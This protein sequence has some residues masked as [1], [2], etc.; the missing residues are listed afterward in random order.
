M[1]NVEIRIQEAMHCHVMEVSVCHHSV[2]K[3]PLVKLVATGTFVTLQHTMAY[4][5]MLL[6][7][8]KEFIPNCNGTF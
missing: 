8:Q 3:Q 4:H 7:M 2:L 6:G 5:G 1:R